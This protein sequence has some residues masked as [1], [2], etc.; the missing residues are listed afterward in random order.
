[1][2]GGDN[3][4]LIVE[5]VN[6]RF[7][8][9]ALFK[10]RNFPVN[11]G[12]WPPPPE[13]KP[14]QS[15]L[16]E[17]CK[18]LRVRIKPDANGMAAIGVIVDADVVLAARWSKLT[19]ILT[20]AAYEV[21]DAPQSG[22]VI[23]NP[24]T[25]DQPRVGLWLMPDNQSDGM[26][27]DL[28]L[29]LISTTDPIRIEAEECVDRLL[30][31]GSLFKTEHRSKAV[32]CTWLAWQQKP[33]RPMGEAIERSWIGHQAP[34]VDDLLAWLERLFSFGLTDQSSN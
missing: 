32:V 16:D 19:Q 11:F 20:R 2:S 21:P 1:M 23:L 4:L 13:T 8:V 10:R 9:S 24:P 15:N 22:G 6:D 33:G 18:Q 25:V 27:E 29:T 3:K 34:L 5:G 14:P 28:V 17:A 7:V 12:W 30:R 31:S 26:L